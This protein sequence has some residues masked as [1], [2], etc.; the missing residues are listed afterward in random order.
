MNVCQ[1]S[2]LLTKWQA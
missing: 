2:V 1:S